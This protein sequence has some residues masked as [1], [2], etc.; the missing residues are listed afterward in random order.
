MVALLE[1]VLVRI[2]EGRS[3]STALMHL[4]STSSQIYQARVYPYELQYCSYLSKLLA[5]LS[6]SFPRLLSPNMRDLL[7]GD[8]NRIGPMPFEFSD[9]DTN[10]L[11][12]STLRHAWLAFPES[13]P[14]TSDRPQLRYYAEKFWGLSLKDLTSAGIQCHVIHL[15]RD[16]RDIVASVKS[17]DLKR[18]FFGFGRR[19]TEEWND[20][21]L[22]LIDSMKRQ[23]L[24]MQEDYELG[25]DCALIYYSDLVTDLESVASQLSM[26]VNKRRSRG[27]LAS[28]V[29]SGPRDLHPRTRP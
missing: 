5:P 13:V 19:P 12:L 16:P 4:L 1:P 26:A 9:L 6:P 21:V 18:G 11:Y 25:L 24:L 10:T 28:T 17:F 29:V 7:E 3:G 8:V 15:L 22:R 14:T 2:I 23:F 20:Y 27:P